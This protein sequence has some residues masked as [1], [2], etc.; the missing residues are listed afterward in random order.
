MSYRGSHLVQ[1]RTVL[2][3]NHTQDL[4][5][6]IY[7]G[8][9]SQ[10]NISYCKVDRKLNNIRSVGRVIQEVHTVDEERCLPQY[11]LMRTVPN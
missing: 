5:R 10:T 1:R 2:L 8:L 7:Y 4:Q 3:L 11:I 9:I 6:V